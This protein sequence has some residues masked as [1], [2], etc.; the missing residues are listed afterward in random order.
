MASFLLLPYQTDGL[1]DNLASLLLEEN[2]AVIW[3]LRP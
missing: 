3:R 1:P 2:Y